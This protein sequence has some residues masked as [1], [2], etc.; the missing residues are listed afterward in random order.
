MKSSVAKVEGFHPHFG[1]AKVGLAD[2]IGLAL[3]AK[4]VAKE[5]HG[6]FSLLLRCLPEFVID[7]TKNITQWVLILP[8]KMTV[9]Y[10]FNNTCLLACPSKN[11]FITVRSATVVDM[12]EIFGVSVR[13]GCVEKRLLSIWSRIFRAKCHNRKVVGNLYPRMG[14]HRGRNS[15][16]DHMFNTLFNLFDP[17]GYSQ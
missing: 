4:E 3:L 1:V 7:T 17:G 12:L 9:F 10:C 13:R 15:W 2:L 16:S 14:G 6:K 5:V 11:V 8:I